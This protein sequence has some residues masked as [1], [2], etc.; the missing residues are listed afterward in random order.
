MTAASR[1]NSSN[2]GLLFDL[3]YMHGMRYDYT[4]AGHCFDQAVRVASRKTEA[5]ALAG[6]R[7]REFRNPEL[8]ERY[9]Q[10]AAE[11]KDATPEI[12]VELA[13]FYERLRRNEEAGA[14]IERAQQMNGSCST[15]L[16][17]R[18][19]LERIGG[20]LEAAEHLLRNLP[21]NME[22]PV[23]VRAAYELGGILDRQGRYDEAMT[24]FEEAKVLLRPQ[25]EQAFY[26]LKVM[27]ARISHL[28][29]HATAGLMK[30]W[31]EDGA[32]MEP[33]R[34]LALLGG[35]PRSGTTLLEQVLDAHP[36]AVSAEETEIFKHDAY[37]PL[38]RVLPDDTAMFEAPRMATPEQ[39]RCARDNYFHF[40]DL[41]L[42]QPI[43]GRLLIDKNPTYTYLVPALIRFFPEIKFLIAL[44]DPRDV[45]LSCFMQHLP[46]NQVGAACLTLEGAIGEYISLMG[47]W[48]TLKTK[49]PNPWLEIRYED[50]VDDLAAVTKR[51]LAFLGLGWDPNVLG[52]DEH[53]RKKLVRSP[54]YADVTR[55]VY[56][57]ARGRWRNYEKYFEPHLQRLEPFVKALGYS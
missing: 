50:M 33:S 21:T 54:T 12:L 18:A 25:A 41:S 42:N 46:L 9:L 31:F 28:T 53:A 27:R 2:P 29:A 47:V 16:L 23:R 1:L 34:R 5:M 11:Q 35:H 22:T 38:M 15:A 51:S 14:L 56:R 8:A 30:Q 45:V 7:S 10:R 52:F 32:Q 49:I 3:G 39:L 26:E 44:R 6:G 20:R 4:Q 36:D 24:V 40:M 48:Q 43:A 55:P 37:V 17:A 13:E 57:H 19:R